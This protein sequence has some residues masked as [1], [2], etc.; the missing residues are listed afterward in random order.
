MPGEDVP[1]EGVPGGQRS[2]ARRHPPELRALLRWWPNWPRRRWLT[3]VLAATAYGAVAGLL[4]LVAS[5]SVQGMAGHSRPPGAR[6][7]GQEETNPGAIAGGLPTA[8][9]TGPASAWMTSPPAPGETAAADPTGEPGT[10]GQ[11]PPGLG[12]A[13][14]PGEAGPGRAGS[15]PSRPTTPTAA[16]TQAR[17]NQVSAAPT[18]QAAPTAAAAPVTQAAA[19]ATGQAQAAGGPG[20][21]VNYVTG[22]CLDSNGDGKIY[23]LSCNGGSYQVWRTSGSGT[24]VLTDAGTGLCLDSDGAGSAYT[25]TCNSGSTQQWRVSTQSDASRMFVNVASGRCLSTNATSY[26]FAGICISGGGGTY[27]RWW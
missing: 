26:V 8:G 19:A 13:A 21:L 2:A 18:A 12:G 22:E 25:R 17:P 9:M 16:T 23:T 5:E 4:F 1:G 11:A 24:V 7:A 20:T 14:S 15:S 3:H 6:A 27:E 10:D